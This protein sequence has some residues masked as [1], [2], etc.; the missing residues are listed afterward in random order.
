MYASGQQVY[1][2]DTV[3]L[4]VNQ[5]TGDQLSGMSLQYSN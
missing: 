3:L 5:L 4:L 2:Y 1:G